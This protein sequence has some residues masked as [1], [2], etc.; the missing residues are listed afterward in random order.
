M[1][2]SDAGED[3]VV[4]C[5]ECDY[6]ANL[7]RATSALPPVDDPQDDLR[8]EE[9]HTPGQK[10][11]E[12]VSQFL[13]E[14][15]SRH[16]KSLVLIVES[17]P[18]L[19]LLRGDH[20]LC[21]TKLTTLVGTETFRQALPEEIRAAFGADPG[22]LGPVGV[23]QMPVY[24]D[25][26]L[27]GR[28]NLICGANKDDYHLL[29]VTPEEDFQPEWV[30][31]RE[32][33]KGDPCPECGAPVEVAK[34]IEIGHIFKLGT[35]YSQSMGATVLDQEGKE[36]PIIMGSYGI[37]VER[38]LSG[39]IELYHDENG[40]ILPRNIA[41]FQVIITLLRP[42]NEEHLK[43]AEKLYA[44]LTARGIDCLLDDR[45]DR[46]G[47]KF[48]DAELIGV[49]IRVTVGRSLGEGMVETFSRREKIKG[50]APADRAVEE[51]IRLLDEYPL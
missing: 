8:P 28:K 18:I 39:A 13:K 23:T 50:E 3:W 4:G 46:P 42:D 45:D 51:V 34:S 26:A 38:I 49:P 27:K 37:G 14:P 35:K 31:L 12:E 25:L 36:V 21:E 33:Q 40:I 9:V 47:V 5:P 24:A 10:T 43:Y 48:K 1:L 7:E 15:K 22:S 16:I 20:Q 17:K 32:V 41:P 19:V 11:I 6:A 2:F 30:D 29:N 44:E